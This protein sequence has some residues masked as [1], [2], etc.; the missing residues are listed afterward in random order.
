MAMSASSAARPAW[1]APPDR[2]ARRPAARR[3]QR[4]PGRAGRAHRGRLFRAAADVRHAGSAGARRDL[5]VLAIGPGMGRSARACAAGAPRSP[6]CPLVLDADAL[7]L[8][9]ARPE[10][11]ELAAQR[12]HPT[13]LTPHPGEAARLLGI[14]QRRH[15][16]D[17]IGARRLSAKLPR[18][19]RA[20]RRRHRDRRPTA[21]TPS[22][23]RGGSWLAQAGSGDRLTGMVAALLGQGMQA[24][25]RAASRGLAA[26]QRSGLGRVNANFALATRPIRDAGREARRGQCRSLQ[27][28]APKECA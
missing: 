1:S 9:A 19:Y 5:D 15:P 8:L 12:S 7:N 23:P 21:A 24:G 2:R 27:A 13:L 3:G 14:L 25:R 4:H 11:A 22:T 10:L 6:P 18:A 20:E 17:R 26:R 16:A 28:L